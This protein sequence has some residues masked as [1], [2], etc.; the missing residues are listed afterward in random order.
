MLYF[1]YIFSK[2][3]YKQKWGKIGAEDINIHLIVTNTIVIQAI[4]F[5]SFVILLFLILFTCFNICALSYLSF[6]LIIMAWMRDL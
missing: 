5:L 6:T 1:S 2:I 3:F 4:L